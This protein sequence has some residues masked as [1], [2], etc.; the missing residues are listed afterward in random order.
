MKELLCNNTMFGIVFCAALW[1]V[2]AF[3]QKKLKNPLANPMLISILLGVTIMLALDIPLEWFRQGADVID[4][5][6]LP[7]TAA[8]GLSIYRQSKVLKEN[9]WP[10]LM[11]CIA[12]C[13]VN[14]VIVSVLCHV[15]DLEELMHASL[16]PRSVTTPIAVALSNQGGDVPA[17]TMASVMVTGLIGAVLGP[18]LVRFLHLENDPVATGVAMGSAS[19]ALGT[20]TAIRMGE[21]E[22]AMSSVAIGVS[23]VLTVILA[24]FW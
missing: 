22:G 4:I 12:G 3:V 23:G 6:L 2:G 20:T 7:A 21:V 10:A 1:Q 9:F 17:V 5:M 19:H 16:L 8:L 24:I 15:M 11:G 13:I 18:W 14:A